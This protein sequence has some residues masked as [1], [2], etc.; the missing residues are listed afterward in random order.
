MSFSV[1]TSAN[2][3]MSLDDM[4][5]ERRKSTRSATAAKK[6]NTAARATGGN[7]AKRAANLAARRGL[8]TTKKANAMEVEKQV[9]RQAGRAGAAG[10][11]GRKK[12]PQK[13]GGGRPGRPK[14][15]DVRAKGR[16][17]AGIASKK[18]QAQKQQHGQ[19]GGGGAAAAVT[20]P[21]Q[22]AIGAAAKAMKNA[23][24]K[25]PKGMQ[26]QISFVPKQQQQQQQKQNQ[27]GGRGGGGG[28]GRGKGRGSGRGGRR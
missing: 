12:T 23:G 3:D 15:G 25:P 1:G 19:R 8:A 5:K 2:V 10:Q 7:K 14:P 17:L 4:I 28:G 22:Q 21:S 11:G 27:G 20:A 18:K 26:M 24:F 6:T 9:R 16:A 13:A